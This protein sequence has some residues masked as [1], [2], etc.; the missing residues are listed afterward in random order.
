MIVCGEVGDCT[1][2]EDLDSD[3]D[4][5]DFFNVVVA[6]VAPPMVCAAGAFVS[7]LTISSSS[8]VGDFVVE[9][10]V[11]DDIDVEVDWGGEVEVE[12]AAAVV[13]LILSAGGLKKNVGSFPSSISAQCPLS[14]C[15][16]DSADNLR[17]G[18]SNG[19]RSPLNLITGNTA[20]S[21][22]CMALSI[23]SSSIYGEPIDDVELRDIVLDSRPLGVGWDVGNESCGGDWIGFKSA[24][25]MVTLSLS[26]SPSLSMVDAETLSGSVWAAP[27]LVGTAA[28]VVAVA[29]AVV[30]STSPSLAVVV[31]ALFF[32]HNLDDL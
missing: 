9:L 12:S 1:A 3:G 30:A 32:Q 20:R 22:G 26:S 31:A 24:I 6:V 10:V 19:T 7:F 15:A 17:M 2:D 5:E 27:F 16:A 14:L 11:D 23:T 4:C 28:V 25:I 18:W 13:A 21:N 29:V 8:F